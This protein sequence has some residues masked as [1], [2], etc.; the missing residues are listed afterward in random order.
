[1]TNLMKNQKFKIPFCGTDV[2]VSIRIPSAVESEE[3]IEKS[4]KPSEI[5]GRFVVS[6]NCPG[7]ADFSN[8]QPS[9]VLSLPGTYSLVQKTSMH[10]CSA[11]SIPEAVTR[12]FS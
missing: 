4:M 6:I 10:I 7:I 3:I 1:M 8:I 12:Y 11:A 9:D 5:F 2:E